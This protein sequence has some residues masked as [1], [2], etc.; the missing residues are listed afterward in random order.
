M[1]RTSGQ[2]PRGLTPRRIAL[3]TLAGLAVTHPYGA[4]NVFVGKAVA[5][6][7][8]MAGD[9]GKAGVMLSEGMSAFLT[10]LGYFEGT[11][12][13]VAA[14]YL[15]GEGALARA[16]LEDSHHAFYEDIEPALAETGAAGFA[17]EAEA[18]V[19]AVRGDAG[20]SAVEETYAALMAALGRTRAAVNPSGYAQLMSVHDLIRLAAAEYDGGVSAG[21]VDVAIEYR[22]SWGFYATAKARAEELAAGGDVLLAKAGV[23]VLAQLDG[24]E[25]LYPDLAAETAATDPSQ[26]AAAAG[27]SEII[28]LRQK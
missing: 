6:Q 19:A 10:R 25:A 24:V 21:A 23:D 8:A 3:A 7:T 18:F 5:E 13:I 12:R 4:A 28:A 9:G 15:G 11:Y 1:T 20:V 22:D 2:A 26:L 16:H 17:V 27:W 14:L